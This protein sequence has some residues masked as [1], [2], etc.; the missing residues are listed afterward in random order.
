MP[1]SST[2]MRAVALRAVVLLALAG[3]A[4]VPLVGVAIL[5]LLFVVYRCARLSRPAK[6]NTEFCDTLIGHRGCRHCVFS[7]GTL[8]PENSMA[9]FAYAA[10]QGA[11]GVELDTRLSAD[12]VPVVM[13]DATSARMLEGADSSVE[14]S[15]LTVERIRSLKWRRSAPAA[16]C[17]NSKALSLSHRASRLS[18]SERA[19]F[20]APV[21]TLEEVIVFCKV[22]WS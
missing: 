8:I 17:P 14:L 3:L 7:D 19:V 4:L 18:D 5:I 11:N 13:H 6:L 10:D 16:D 1:L 2:N 9:A 15:K 12:G 20:D 21:P 22:L